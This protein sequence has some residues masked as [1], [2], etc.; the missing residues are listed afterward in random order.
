VTRIAVLGDHNLDFMTHREL[1]AA[2]ELFPRWAEVEWIATDDPRAR[3]LKDIDGI[4]VAPGGP[5]R[6]DE[7]VYRAIGNAREHGIPLLGTCG[8]F[9]YAIV[10][11]ARNVAGLDVAHAE[12]EDGGSKAVI[13]RLACSLVGKERLVTCVPDSRL[14]DVCG[15]LP[16]AGFHW[17]SYG[18]AEAFVE[19]LAASGLMICA[20][21]PD[22]GVEAIEL[23]EHPFFVATLFQPQIGSGAFH[24]VHPLIG[25]FID[26]SREYAESVVHRHPGR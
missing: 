1:D 6:D 3:T 11:F 22:A 15:T 9:Q 13:A 7:A 10:E 19:R 12:I 14:A 2:L 8:G 4:W 20:H 17:C 18:L 25:A 21:A 23:P 16:F 24:T 5:Y 26:A